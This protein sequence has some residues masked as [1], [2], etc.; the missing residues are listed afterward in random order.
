MADPI[1]TPIVDSCPLIAPIWDLSAFVRA[2]MS[3]KRVASW[4]TVMSF[5]S[6]VVSHV[7]V[8]TR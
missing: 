6:L 8:S 4:N 7:E 1:A 2:L 5:Y 3:T